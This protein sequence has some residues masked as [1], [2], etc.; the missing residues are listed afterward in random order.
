MNIYSSHIRNSKTQYVNYEM[1]DVLR[2]EMPVL[3]ITVKILRN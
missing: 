1:S 2:R 3:F